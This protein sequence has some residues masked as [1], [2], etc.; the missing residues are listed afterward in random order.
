MGQYR[1]IIADPPWQY[2]NG[3]CQGGVNE[4]YPTMENEAICRLPVSQLA[5]P[6][7]VLLLWATWPKLTDALQVMAAWGFDYLTGLPWVKIAGAPAMD[8]GGE[9]RIRPQYGVGFWVR[10]CTEPILIGRRGNVSPPDDGWVGLLSENALHSRKP[11]N[12]YEYAESM[13]GPYLE[14]FAR[15]P[16]AGWDAYGNQVVGSITLGVP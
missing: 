2:R 11:D 14:M 1:T 15:R 5:A 6:D 10:G 16:R 7:A 4:Q 13:P 8:F 3:G 9:W 12:L